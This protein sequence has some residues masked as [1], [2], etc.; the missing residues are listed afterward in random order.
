MR[1]GVVSSNANFA[2]PVVT[3]LDRRGHDVL[4][5]QYTGDPQQ[6]MYQLGQLKM[7]AERVF[8]DFAQPPL[9]VVLAE[10]NCPIIVRLH[11]I[12]AYNRA[13]LESLPWEK[14]ARLFFVAP[15]VQRMVQQYTIRPPK[16]QAVAHV[17]VD[18]NF[19]CPGEPGTRKWEPPYTV[20]I[21]GNVVPKKRVYTAVQLVHDLGPDYHF[22]CW[23]NGAMD[24]GYGNPEYHRNVSDLISELGMEKR[25]RGG[26]KQSPEDLRERMQQA[27]F[28]LS[29]SNEEGCHMTVAEGM[30][31]GCVPLVNCWKGAREVYPEEW[32]W[33]SP[34]GFFGLVDRWEALDEEEKAALSGDMRQ[35]VAERYE[36]SVMAGRI[37]DAITGPLDARSVGEWYSANMLEHMAAQDG[38]ARQQAALER[39]RTHLPEGRPAK[40]LELGCGTGY[41]SRTLAQDG[42]DCAGMDLAGGLLQ[43]ASEHNPGE[44]RFYQ[45]D[46]TA[47]LVRGPWDIITC[48]DMLEHVPEKQHTALLARIALELAPGGVALFNFPHKAE[49]TQIIEEHVFPKV[50]RNKLEQVGLEVTEYGEALDVYFEITAR[51]PVGGG[52][53]CEC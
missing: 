41:L 22:E 3:E 2:G 33:K 4:M 29:A 16:S 49:D 43:W 9:E 24:E 25:F 5:F 15:H 8:V 47:Q 7:Q 6:D 26:A 40:V 20:L 52:A 30:A 23:G 48:I 32:V 38:N 39:V 1:V 19:W 35:W 10:F 45:A 13:Y 11:R 34:K 37:A 17:G 42:H 18:T 44:A 31:C 27:H 14:V 46:A 12:E 51:K 50:L 53:A 36:A 28:I 21:A